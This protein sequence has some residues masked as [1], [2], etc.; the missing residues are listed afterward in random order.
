M[1]DIRSDGPLLPL[2]KLPSSSSRSRSTSQPHPPNS[3]SPP[4]PYSPSPSPSRSP[5]I[6]LPLHQISNPKS[7]HANP[8]E[9]EH[10]RNNKRKALIC[11]FLAVM[12]LLII[13]LAV[14][15]VIVSKAR[16]KEGCVGND[17]EVLGGGAV[18]E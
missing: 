9:S 17:G 4:P 16:D 13:P 5:S 11:I 15:S 8:Q 1:A 18:C 6:D 2:Y 12:L 10:R 7:H 3:S 14:F